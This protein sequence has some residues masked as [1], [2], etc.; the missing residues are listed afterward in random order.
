MAEVVKNVIDESLKAIFV[1]KLKS[2]DR[3]IRVKYGMIMKKLRE[4]FSTYL[5]EQY[6]KYSTINTIAFKNNQYQLKEIYQPLTLCENR[7]E[8]LEGSGFLVEGYIKEII[9][10]HQKILITDTAGMGKSTLLKRMFLDAVENGHEVPIFI[11]LR[12]LSRDNNIIN[13]I[14]KQVS[15]IDKSFDV[16]LL[17]A[18]IKSGGFVF[19]LDGF[20]EIP[21]MIKS[22]VTADIQDFI[23]KADNNKFI[24]TSRPEDIL[25]SF[26]D[27][28]SFII[29]PLGREEAF[30]LLGRYDN[31][32]N[33]SKLLISKLDSGDYKMIDEFLGNPLLVSLLFT[34]FSYKNTIPLKKHVFYDQVY[35]ALYED[36]DLSKG[37]GFSRLKRTKLSVDDFK[38]VLR[39]LG[40]LCMKDQ[41]IEFDRSSLIGIL[42]SAK[43]S[44]PDLTFDSA[45][46][47]FDILTNVPLFIKDGHL[48]RWAHKSLQEYFAAL[49]IYE[50]AKDKQGVILTN[51]YNCKKLESYV[52]MLDIYHDIDS[53]G[54][55]RYILLP[56]LNSYI[57]YHDN[58][59]AH[60]KGVAPREVDIRL[61]LLYYYDFA[62]KVRDFQDSGDH[63]EAH[64]YV[65]SYMHKLDSR[66]AMH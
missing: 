1:P 5:L 8:L 48:Y 53:L 61:S 12:R 41:R 32:G 26:G 27:F 45:D 49:C 59:C 34:A 17:L 28:K 30:E 14:L 46:F 23:Q 10:K 20:D 6:N 7:R 21:S 36:H 54:F 50:D 9:D 58:N 33:T 62:I 15:E 56:F 24:L 60:Y 16:D 11:E 18:L 64:E 51:I 4:H 44:C 31:N 37:D 42:D 47:I 2:L 55:K 65:S 43:R 57:S 19:F 38:R 25:S 63:S 52:N 22:E 40:Y 29:K 66:S 39:F 35:D 13:E 3:S